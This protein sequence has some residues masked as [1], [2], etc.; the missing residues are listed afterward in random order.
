MAVKPS[1]NS[2]IIPRL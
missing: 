2:N 1:P